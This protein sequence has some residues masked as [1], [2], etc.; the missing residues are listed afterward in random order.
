MCSCSGTRYGSCG[1]RCAYS[2]HRQLMKIFT[3]LWACPAVAFSRLSNG[4]WKLMKSSYAGR[5]CNLS[6]NRRTFANQND[7]MVFI[8]NN[9][10]INNNRYSPYG[11]KLLDVPKPWYSYHNSTSFQPPIFKSQ[12]PASSIIFLVIPP[13]STWSVSKHVCRYG[14]HSSRSCRAEPSLHSDSGFRILC[15][16]ARERPWA[17]DWFR[18]A[19]HNA[20]SLGSRMYPSSSMNRGSCRL[21]PSKLSEGVVHLPIMVFNYGILTNII[22]RLAWYLNNLF[23]MVNIPS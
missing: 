9:Y 3:C 16:A 7:F 4:C 14:L 13:S 10:D 1:T 11:K 22:V 21:P 20:R 15:R 23:F 17:L 2:A 12:F 6:L 19:L 18:A 5:F 8:P